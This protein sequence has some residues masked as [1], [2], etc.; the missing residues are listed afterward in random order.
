[1]LLLD[2]SIDRAVLH[3]EGYLSYRRGV[4]P[5]MLPLDDTE[6]QLSRALLFLQDGLSAM[7]GP[8]SDLPLLSPRGTLLTQT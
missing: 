5:L 7:F 8:V 2:T 4:G 3:P 6:V 1:M